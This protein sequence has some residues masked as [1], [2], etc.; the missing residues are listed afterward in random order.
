MNSRPFASRQST[1][2]FVFEKLSY[3]VTTHKMEM[4]AI[5]GFIPEFSFAYN[6]DED[7]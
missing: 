4:N 6:D 7:E 5:D 1:L 2:E 3:I